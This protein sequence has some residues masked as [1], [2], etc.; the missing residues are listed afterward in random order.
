M[1][2]LIAKQQ[3]LDKS[4]SRTNDLNKE[5]KELSEGMSFITK[6]VLDLHKSFKTGQED[7][8][9]TVSIGKF[10]YI[11]FHVAVDYRKDVMLDCISQF[12]NSKLLSSASNESKEFVRADYDELDRDCDYDQLKHVI[13]DVVSGRLQLKNRAGNRSQVL[14]WLLQNPYHIDFVSSIRTA[15]SKT[16]FRNM[17]GG[18]KA[19]AI[20]ELIF[21]FDSGQYPILL[22]QP[23]DDIDIHG[24]TESLSNFIKK[25]KRNRQIFIVSHSAN[26]VLCSDA[27]NIIVAENGNDFK[28]HEG[29]IEDEQIKKDIVNIL[30]GGEDA[31]NLRMRKLRIATASEYYNQPNRGSINPR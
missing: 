9:K 7:I 29:A 24:V 13:D 10:D 26:L 18:Q 1:L 22:D 12:I 2:E 31:L 14:S 21:K 19:I 17:T 30:E 4:I 28:Y 25:Q 5:I 15:N 16:A 23:E 6:K 11:S 27:E 3:E 8:Y 20:L